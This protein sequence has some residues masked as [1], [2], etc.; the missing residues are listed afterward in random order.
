VQTGACCVTNLSGQVSC[1]QTTESQCVGGQDAYWSGVGSLCR[2][3]DPLTG[4]AVEIS[5]IENNPLYQFAGSPSADV[6]FLN[7]VYVFAGWEFFQIRG[8]YRDKSP[9]SA[10][11]GGREMGSVF[12]VFR[13]HTLVLDVPR[14]TSGKVTFVRIGPK[15]FGE[16]Q[17]AQWN[18]DYQEDEDGFDI[19]P[20]G[21]CT[22]PSQ[23]VC[24]NAPPDDV[25]RSLRPT[26]QNRGP[27]SLENCR[28]T[29][30]H[31]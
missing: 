29:V 12:D 24:A 15:F 20:H 13:T 8:F 26:P 23:P 6:T 11:Y 18:L 3:C 14:Y 2:P 25:W 28:L 31:V 4:V 22:Q 9:C 17:Y 27:W 19:T 1:I 21:D 10:L 30:T 7:G 5:G 16:D